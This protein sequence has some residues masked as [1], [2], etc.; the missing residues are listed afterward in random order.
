MTRESRNSVNLM[1]LLIVSFTGFSTQRLG[2]R[3]AEQG[4]LR[5]RRSLFIFPSGLIEHSHEVPFSQL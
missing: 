3:Q 5:R 4:H 1:G 2:I